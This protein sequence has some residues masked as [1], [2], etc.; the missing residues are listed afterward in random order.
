MGADAMINHC[1]DTSPRR[2]W[3]IGYPEPEN[4]AAVGK[5]I[6]GASRIFLYEIID[7]G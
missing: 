3:I 1:F 4:T 2:G 6:A 5:T 7:Q